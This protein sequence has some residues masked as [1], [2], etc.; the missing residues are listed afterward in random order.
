MG[1]GSIAMLSIVAPLDM[2]QAALGGK[3]CMTQK[4]RIAAK[5]RK[6]SGQL[7]PTRISTSPQGSVA[8]YQHVELPTDKEALEAY[9]ALPFVRAFNDIKPLGD[10]VSIDAVTQNDTS[11]LDFKIVCKAADYLELAEL[12]PRSEPFGRKAFTTGSLNTHDYAH[13]IY[14]K[15]INKKQ[16]AYGAT[17]HRTL[18][19]LYSTHWQFLPGDSLIACVKSWCAR[20]GVDFAGVFILNM[21]AGNHPI[22][23]TI[24][25]NLGPPPPPPNAFKKLRYWNLPPGNAS[26][27]IDTSAPVE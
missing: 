25:P 5:P 22:V 1:T 16:K 27:S 9:F 3:Q 15:I 18:L 26:W 8:E 12:N 7:G 20:G 6:A 21:I 17:A 13:W 10:D 11:D 4:G 24:L 19:L 14:S 2:R 23:E